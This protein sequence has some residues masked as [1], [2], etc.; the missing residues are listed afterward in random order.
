MKIP[1]RLGKRLICVV[2]CLAAVLLTA[3]P[4]AAREPIGKTFLEQ[5]PLRFGAAV[6]YSPRDDSMIIGY[7]EQGMDITVLETVGDFYKVDCCGMTGYVSASLVAEDDSGY[8][9]RDL[10]VGE[11]STLFVAMELPQRL[12]MMAQIADTAVRYV[13]VPYVW[14]GTSPRGFDCSGFTQY[15]FARCGISIPRTCEGQLGEGL[16]IPKEE[17]QCGDLVFFAGT[18]GPGGVVSHVG[19]YLGGGK[20]IHAGSRGITIVELESSYFVKHY[21]CARRILVGEELGSLPL[22]TAEAVA[23]QL[24]N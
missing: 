6:H 16:I 18:T 19:L 9:V 24:W 23:Q 2:L 11:Q 8:Y 21:L 12:D 20:L 4:A 13:G 5:S 7:L 10:I 22:K 15:V 14:G 3:L 1:V 17:L